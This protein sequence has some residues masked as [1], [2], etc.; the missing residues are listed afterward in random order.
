V[1]QLQILIVEDEALLSMDLEQILLE[2]GTQVVGIAATAQQAL[3]M[4]KAHRPN[5][6]FVDV[7]L[8]D[9]ATGPLIARELAAAGET[10]VVFMTANAAMLPEDL[11]GAIGVISKP[12][13]SKGVI[14]ALAYLHQGILTPPPA[15]RKPQNLTLSKVYAERWRPA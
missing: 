12:Y 13:V 4:A 9:G 15:L 7:Q 6:A 5:L 11:A 10:A 8:S 14:S 3:Q 2:A 1:D